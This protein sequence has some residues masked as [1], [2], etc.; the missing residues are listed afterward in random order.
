MGYARFGSGRPA[1][2]LMPHWASNI[3]S[4]WQ[5]P[6]FERFA[7]KLASL[8]EVVHFDKRGVGVS[9][10]LPGDT[11][12][13]LDTATDDALGVLDA[14]SIGPAIVVAADLAGCAGI[15]LAASHPQRVAGLVLIGA[16]ARLRDD[17]DYPIGFDERAMRRAV[18]A[19]HRGWIEGGPAPVRAQEP[20]WADEADYVTATTRYRR[21]TVSPSRARAMARQVMNWDL[22][23]EASSVACPTLVIHRRDDRYIPVSHGRFLAEAIPGAQLRELDGAD[24]T[25]WAGPHSDHIVNAIAQA[26]VEAG[27]VN[28]RRRKRVGSSFGWDA[29]TPAEAR[30]VELLANGATNKEAA[31]LLGISPRTVETHLQAAYNKLGIRTRAELAREAAGVDRTSPRG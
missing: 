8:T 3:E 9:D 27:A 1:I 21:T 25:P 20:S 14:C 23:L 28:R 6:G 24:H 30:V 4:I 10:R 29:L 31:R 12:P 5:E 18:E 16:T 17:V 11:L 2:L 22:R 26:T 7:A 19:T 13:D 15:R